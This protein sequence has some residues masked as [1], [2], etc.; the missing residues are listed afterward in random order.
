MNHLLRCQRLNNRYFAV[1]HG[2]SLANQQGII[3]SHPQNGVSEYGL[4]ETGQ[5]QVIE[6]VGRDRQLDAATLIVSSDFR[7]ARETA[8]II[9]RQ[10]DSHSTLSFDQRLRE[11]NFG[12]LELGPDSAYAGVWQEDEINA[13]NQLRAVE[14]PNQVMARVSELVSDYESRYS[15][16]TVLLVSH[17]D[18]LQILQ[19]AFAKQDASNHRRQRH[20]ETAEIRPLL[21]D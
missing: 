8:E 1:R 12:E 13:N 10:L 16:A 9:H 11:R 14:S 21:L 5:L 6:S 19:T 7:R 17:G 3:V 20:L 18:A 2:N 15:E 4:S